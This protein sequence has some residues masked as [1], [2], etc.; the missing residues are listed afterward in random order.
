MRLKILKSLYRSCLLFVFALSILLNFS[1]CTLASYRFNY[2]D[3]EDEI[4]AVE[5]FTYKVS[6]EEK[7]AEYSNVL[8][9]EFSRC[10]LQEKLAAEEIDAFTF[11]L[12]CSDFHY[13]HTNGGIPFDQGV[14]LT[15]K[16]QKFQVITWGVA[17]GTPL[18]FICTYDQACTPLEEGYVGGAA[19]GLMAIFANYFQ[20]K[21]V[22]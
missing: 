18:T 12:E 17:N 19:Y 8:P 3:L 21:I 11:E 5:L 10:A 1:S 6:E 7:S 16:S 20:T 22:I 2:S 9:F 15:Y 14:C 4:V 13:G